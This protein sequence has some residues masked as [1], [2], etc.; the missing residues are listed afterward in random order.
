MLPSVC[1]IAATDHDDALLCR[2]YNAFD[3]PCWS[4][5]PGIWPRASAHLAG[6]LLEGVL[7]LRVVQLDGLDAAQIV[8]V[9]RQLLLLPRRL[10]PLC[11]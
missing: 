9:P 2:S 7:G 11:L 6:C 1:A 4:G 3:V 10:R 8:Q 5:D